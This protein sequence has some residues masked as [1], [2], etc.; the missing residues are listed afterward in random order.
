MRFRKCLEIRLFALK[1]TEK[2]IS[3]IIFE[4][5]GTKMSSESEHI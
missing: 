5:C 3:I 4:V 1:L 2:L